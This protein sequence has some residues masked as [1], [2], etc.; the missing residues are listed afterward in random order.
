MARPK[1]PQPL[2][3]KVIVPNMIHDGKGGT[4]PVGA[5]IVVTEAQAASLKAKGFAE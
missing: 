5:V 3:V 1:K 4:F 2:T